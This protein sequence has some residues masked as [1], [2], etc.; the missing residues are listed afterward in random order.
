MRD[1]RPVDELSIAELERVLAL[2]KRE[3]RLNRLQQGERAARRVA[4]VRPVEEDEERERLA[5]DL[6]LNTPRY[7]DGAAEH[8]AAPPPPPKRRRRPLKETEDTPQFEDDVEA[9]LDESPPDINW[10][11]WWN[12]GLLLVEVAAVIGLIALFVGLFQSFQDITAKSAAIQQDY[13]ATARAQYIPPTPTSVF[14]IATVVLPTG[15][16]FREG[17]AIFNLEEVP[18]AYRDQFASYTA[19]LPVTRPTPSPEAPIRIRIPKLN[20]DSAVVAGD[21]WEALKLG[22]GHH[23]GSVN[24]GQAGNMVLSA[25]NDIYGEI[26]RHLD[27]LSVGDEII[28]STRTRDYTYVVQS[29]ADARGYTIVLPTDTWVLSSSATVRQV[30]L[31]SCY[32]YRVDD[33]RIVVFATLR[34]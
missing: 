31:I 20:V 17:E 34:G 29:G 5:P 6:A 26:F 25:H 9:W 21:D 33:K 2:K 18:A 27:Q 19:Q 1:K 13:E 16:T 32:P 11:V 22:V 15:H 10:R 8:A 24:P 4:P 3:E 14:S 7:D 28:V 12:R 23:L 30:T